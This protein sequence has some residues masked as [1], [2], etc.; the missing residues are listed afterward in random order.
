MSNS[1]DIVEP[2]HV[3]LPVSEMVQGEFFLLLWFGQGLHGQILRLE[4]V[5]GM[6][7]RTVLSFRAEFPHWVN[8]QSMECLSSYRVCVPRDVLLLALFVCT[9]CLPDD[10][11]EYSRYGWAHGCCRSWMH[12]PL[13]G[14]GRDFWC[15][16]LVNLHPSAN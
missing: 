2:P 11:L 14:V 9:Q 8:F 3:H 1:E 6:L 7:E 13:D 4:K 5:P 10:E 16:H 12:V 15:S